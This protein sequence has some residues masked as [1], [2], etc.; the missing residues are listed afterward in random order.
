MSKFT[1]STMYLLMMLSG[2]T[3]VLTANSWFNAWVGLEIS[4][5]S[6][7]PLTSMKNKEYSSEAS[8]KYFI[9][10]TISSIFILMSMMLMIYSKNIISYIITSSLIFKCGA[11]PLHFWFPNVVE[12]LDWYQNF[13]LMTAQKFSPLILLS[14]NSEKINIIM[15]TAIMSSAVG[16]IGGINE[17][18]TNKMLAFSSINHKCWILAAMTINNCLW[19]M[20]FFVYCLVLMSVM[21][22][23]NYWQISHM[24]QS[25][26]MPTNSLILIMTT[27]LS[28]GGFPPLMGFFPKMLVMFNMMDLKM[29]YVSLFFIMMSI[30]TLYFYSRLM[31]SIIL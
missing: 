31:F 16:A 3:I 7:I 4:L 23:M 18:K 17:L 21:T 27:L 5:M 30:I 20:Y 28:L 26:W 11:A 6:F 24:S 19:M 9:V 13:L 15:L 2:M 10:Q 12:G 25:S 29:F 8:M 14:L 22:L 1:S